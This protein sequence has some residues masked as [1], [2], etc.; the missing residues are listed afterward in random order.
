MEKWHYLLP[1]I[2]AFTGWILALAGLKIYLK[3][4]SS[5]AEH[6]LQALPTQMLGNVS[7][8][9]ALPLIEMHVDDFLKNKLSKEHPMI[10]MFIG[11]KTIASLKRTFMQEI[12]L[13]MPQVLEKLVVDLSV[14]FKT[15]LPAL[16]REPLKKISL[17]IQLAGLL[18]GFIIGIIHLLINLLTS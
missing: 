5:Q 10:S 14:S 6:Y 11:D 8:G 4:I 7:P 1:L 16:I 3:R 13:M 15:R 18:L 9:A 17:K 2:G 12:E